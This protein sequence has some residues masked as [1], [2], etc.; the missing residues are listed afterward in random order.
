MPLVLLIRSTTDNWGRKE[1]A[2]RAYSV[3]LRKGRA[4]DSIELKDSA[5]DYS[6][7]DLVWLGI[8]RVVI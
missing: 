3:L 1:R 8:D 5:A 7:P 6:K 4:Y 2:Y